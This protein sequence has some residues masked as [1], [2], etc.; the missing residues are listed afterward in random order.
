MNAVTTEIK[1]QPKNDDTKLDKLLRINVIDWACR[2]NVTEC[3]NYTT[4]EFNEWLK[5]TNKK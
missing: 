1:Y 4:S 3:T 5:N 2:A